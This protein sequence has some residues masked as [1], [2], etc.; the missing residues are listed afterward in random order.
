M[1]GL[2]TNVLLR[3]LLNDGDPQKGVADRFFLD[4]ADRDE[5]LFVNQI[6]LCELIWVLSRGLRF[7]RQR[8]GDIIGQLLA[9]A[10]LEFEDKDLVEEAL[11]LYALSKADFADCLIAARNRDAGCNATV[12]LD[13]TAGA[14]DH[15]KLPE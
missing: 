11:S 2:D 13:R 7:D 12:T 9:A 8:A 6:V 15:F 1:T 14:L 4:S 3:Y 10:Q 5:K